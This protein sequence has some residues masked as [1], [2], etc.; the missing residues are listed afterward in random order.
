MENM[1]LGHIPTHP[2]EIIKDELIERRIQQKV[3]AEQMGMSY[4]ILNDIL[5][6]R[7]P[8]ST[9]TALMFE[10]ALN[11]PATALLKLQMKYNIQMAEQNVDLMKR[12]AS[13]RKMVASVAI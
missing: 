11:I 8:V 6:G 10:A 3:L 4:K 12:L 1:L 13:I 9:E 7:R 5:N 2:G